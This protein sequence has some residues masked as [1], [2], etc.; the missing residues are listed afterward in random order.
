[1]V[2]TGCVAQAEG[3][4]LL[5][6][7]KYIDAII[8]PQSYHEFNKVLL[9]IEKNNKKINSTEFDVIEKFDTLNLLKIRILMFHHF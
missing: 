1:M 9:K 2:V 7:E 8:G 3:E 4:L 6:N 5:N